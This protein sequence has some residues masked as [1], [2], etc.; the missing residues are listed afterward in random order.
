MGS[1]NYSFL[2]WYFE[3]SQPQRV[4]SWLKT[5]FNLAPIYSARKS[6]NHKL[7]INYKI[8]HDTNLHKTKHTQTSD[9]PLW[10]P[11]EDAENPPTE[12]AANLLDVIIRLLEEMTDIY[13]S[14][15]AEKDEI[16]TVLL[17]KIT[18]TMTDRTTTMK[19]FDKK[20]EEFIRS[21]IG[22]QSM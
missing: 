13:I 10:G 2:S 11:T 3:P 16:F 15:D 1:Q 9:T 7:T 12:D 4:T 21:K 6:S 18:S 19:S 20:L 5:M 8:S 17:S 22:Q 14:T